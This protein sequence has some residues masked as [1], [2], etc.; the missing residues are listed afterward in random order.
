MDLLKCLE[1]GE[2]GEPIDNNYGDKLVTLCY[3][4]GKNDI[5]IWGLKARRQK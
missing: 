4:N 3:N 2:Q 5:F 1:W